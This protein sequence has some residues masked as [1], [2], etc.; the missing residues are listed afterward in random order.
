MTYFKK[1]PAIFAIVLVT[2]CQPA[3]AEE[4][5]LMTAGELLNNCN[6][7]YSPGSPTPFC[8]KYVGDFVFMM[9]AL[10]QAEQSPPIF[11][12]NP[13]MHP[14]EEVT[15]KVHGYLRAKTSRASQPAQDLVIEALNKGYP[16]SLNNQT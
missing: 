5:E 14:L 4:E 6:E 3:M 2:L 9:M 11:C 13:Q 10:Q 16:C 15:E 7:G 8:M 12:I 1:L